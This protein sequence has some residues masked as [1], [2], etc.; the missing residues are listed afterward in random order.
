M[1]RF[2]FKRNKERWHK[3]TFSLN[4]GGHKYATVSPLEGGLWYWY[5][6]GQN[7]AS[8]PCLSL[9]AAKAECLSYAKTKLNELQI[10]FKRVD[11]T[12]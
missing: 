5:G 3:T 8:A 7:S 2:S 10:K 4:Y 1:P 11:T 9:E 6:F 12:N